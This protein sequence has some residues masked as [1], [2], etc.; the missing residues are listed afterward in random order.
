MKTKMT[1]VSAD[2]CNMLMKTPTGF[3]I[4][5]SVF[6]PVDRDPS[7]SYVKLVKLQRNDLAY[8]HI[9]LNWTSWRLKPKFFA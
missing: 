1:R 6:F 5:S 4:L 9:G 3:W 8:T 2:Y 7:A